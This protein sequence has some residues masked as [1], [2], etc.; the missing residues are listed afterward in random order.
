MIFDPVIFDE[1]IFDAELVL[2]PVLILLNKNVLY[3]D[4]EDRILD[5]EPEKRYLT[6][7]IE[8]RVLQ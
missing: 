5:A 8:L 6:A 3:A 4:E 7:N 1:N 2:P